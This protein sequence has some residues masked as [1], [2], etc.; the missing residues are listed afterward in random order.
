MTIDSFFIK[1]FFANHGRKIVWILIFRTG[2]TISGLQLV[3]K[4]VN[5]RRIGHHILA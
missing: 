1:G 5:Q 2:R 4:Q 3:Q